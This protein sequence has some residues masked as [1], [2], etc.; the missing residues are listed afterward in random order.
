MD[1]SRKS[2]SGSPLCGHQN[3]HSLQTDLQHGRSRVCHLRMWMPCER[4]GTHM[5]VYSIFFELVT[6]S[7]RSTSE[8]CLVRCGHPQKVPKFAA[9]AGCCSVPMEHESQNGRFLQATLA[10]EEEGRYRAECMHLSTQVI[11]KFHTRLHTACSLD[12]V[13]IT[14]YSV[15]Y[16]SYR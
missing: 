13:R 6:Y 7:W 14:G 3:H 4:S 10:V 12:S 8:S 16:S 15:P 2:P 1:R 11:P 9:Q 5:T